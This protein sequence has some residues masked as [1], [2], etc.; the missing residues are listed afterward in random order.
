MAHEGVTESGKLRV[1]SFPLFF[2]VADNFIR[3]VKGVKGVKGIKVVGNV[4]KT[5]TPLMPLIALTA[6]SMVSRLMESRYTDRITTTKTKTLHRQ[7]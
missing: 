4:Q 7:A 2:F 6:L 1:E 3:D 5:L